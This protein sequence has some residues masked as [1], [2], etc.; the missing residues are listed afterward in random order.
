M[1][2]STVGKNSIK[3]KGKEV[4]FIVDPSWEMPKIS[5]DAVVLLNGLENIDVSRVTD[6][7][8]TIQG[9]GGY[10]VGGAKIS[11]LRTSKGIIYKFLIDG[12]IV[13]VG[14]TAESKEDGFSAC[15]I[16]VINTNGEIN[17]PFVTAL[18]PK[19]AVLYGD[20]KNDLAKELGAEN[21][22]LIPKITITKDKLPEKMEIV[23]LG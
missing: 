19:V 5:A 21:I 13:I 20:K 11:G 12:L 16:A 14:K 17:E 23:V 1:D 10:E 3:L 15:Q 2:I 18:E 6:S 7:R 22:N 8:I 4:T 9:A